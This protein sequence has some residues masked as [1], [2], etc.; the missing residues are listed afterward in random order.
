MSNGGDDRGVVGVEPF[1]P[2]SLGFFIVHNI[3]GRV[4]RC[5]EQKS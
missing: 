3:F 5:R 1:S 4:A 2:H